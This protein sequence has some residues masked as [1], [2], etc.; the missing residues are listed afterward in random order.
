M[1]GRSIPWNEKIR[2]IVEDTDTAENNPQIRRKRDTSSAPMAQK[3]D[4]RS[5]ILMD[6]IW[7]CVK[8][9]CITKECCHQQ[10]QHPKIPDGESVVERSPTEM[11]IW[12]KST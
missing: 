4:T 7:D 3:S 10:R 2:R 6:M 9:F 11:S 12:K 8:L 1:S 5:I